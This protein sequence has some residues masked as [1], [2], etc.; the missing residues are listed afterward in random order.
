MRLV[1][2][3][4][5]LRG[6][7]FFLSFNRLRDYLFFLFF[8]PPPPPRG[9]KAKK[10]LFIYLF[11]PKECGIIGNTKLAKKQL[12]QQNTIKENQYH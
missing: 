8:L 3:I 11:T 10:N 1:G 9:L 6:C 4:Q 5:I 7:V 2:P 12:I